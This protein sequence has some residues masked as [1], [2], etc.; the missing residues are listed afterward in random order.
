MTDT[1]ATETTTTDPSTLVEMNPADL[2][3]G[4]NVRL[5]ARLDKRF[6]ASIRERGV[7]E[8]IIAQHD[9]DGRTVV[10]AGQRRTLAAVEAGL[11]TVPVV[12]TKTRAEVDR[13]IDQMAENDHRAG[14]TPAERVAA[15]EQ[16]SLLGLTAAQVAKRTATKRE[17]VT[18]ALTVAASTKAKDVVSTH[19]ALT[20]EQAAALADLEDDPESVETVMEA[21][22]TGKGVDFA[23]KRATQDR[24][25]RRETRELTEQ[26]EAQGLRVVEL[27]WMNES[28]LALNRLRDQ[29][30]NPLDPDA[31]AS[32]PGHAVT[33]QG[34]WITVGGCAE[35]CDHDEDDEDGPQDCEGCAHAEDTENVW[36]RSLAPVCVDWVK[37]GHRTPYG[38]TPQVKAADMSEAERAAAKAQRAEVIR[39]NKDWTTA[40]AVRL[41]W[42]TKFATRKTL[43]RD[44]G[45]F[46]AHMIASDANTLAHHKVP[47]TA[48]KVL[49]IQAHEWNVRGG[50][51]QLIEKANDKRAA[52]LAL[53]VALAACEAR[54]DRNDWRNNVNTTG[55][56]LRALQSWGYELSEVEQ[57]AAGLWGEHDEKPEE[58]EPEDDP[59]EEPEAQEY[60]NEQD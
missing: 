16:L 60:E 5:D 24:D 25:E 23:L 34:R 13:I 37:H 49:G 45:T 8:P 50:I 19:P 44:A 21:I 36:V 39:L 32:C 51:S 6:I 52:V 57:R 46:L 31:H 9:E 17:D 20:L 53:A 7:I 18:A 2:I 1:T 59:N 48:A 30:G 54:T 22:K 10:I 28:T 43:P 26:A 42:L 33:I 4:A 58:P 14:I 56:Y 41:A 38:G 15:V 47:S 55:R 35:N 27:S 3:V 11:P 29:D 40:E 12:I